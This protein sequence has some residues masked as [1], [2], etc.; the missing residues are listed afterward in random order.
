[1]WFPA[2]LLIALTVLLSSVAQDLTPPVDPELQLQGWEPEI[3]SG[4][5]T[6]VDEPFAGNGTSLLERRAYCPGLG[7]SLFSTAGAYN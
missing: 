2:Q 7:G 4:N 6:S 5:A 3:L 1:M